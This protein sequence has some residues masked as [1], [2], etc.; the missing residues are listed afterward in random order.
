MGGAWRGRVSAVALLS[1]L[2][3]ACD[4]ASGD[5]PEAE[6][7]GWPIDRPPAD[8]EV[9]DPDLV[10]RIVA[11]LDLHLA[12]LHR[13]VAREGEVGELA[14]ALA[15]SI[16]TDDVV[17]DVLERLG[18]RQADL[19]EDISTP[20]SAVV[21]VAAETTDCV[22]ALIRRDV[23]PMLDLPEERAIETWQV[24]LVVVDD[25]DNG[26]AWRLARDAPGDELPDGCA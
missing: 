25:S 13:A 3:V 7:S 26:T 5:G 15:R 8:V 17:A 11:E 21:E 12:D 16:Y 4:G 24:T 23:G 1:A 9:I 22:D 14:E 10:L 19:R 6:P 2:A 20:R 18:E